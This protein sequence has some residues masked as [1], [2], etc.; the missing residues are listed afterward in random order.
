MRVAI[1]M[2]DRKPSRFGEIGRLFSFGIEFTLTI[3]I[4][5]GMGMFVD[6]ICDSRP[7]G[8]FIGL[9][10]GIGAAFR[11]LY[12]LASGLRKKQD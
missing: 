10:G 5:L 3:M 4:G 1:D 9:A 8:M 11:A 2:N 7:A 12:K 6:S